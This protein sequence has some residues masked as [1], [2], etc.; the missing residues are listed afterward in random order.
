MLRLLHEQV[1][2]Y[3]KAKRNLE[4]AGHNLRAAES[5]LDCAFIRLKN[6]FIEE[7]KKEQGNVEK[8]WNKVLDRLPKQERP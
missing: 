5:A 6:H 8:E 4:L 7:S 3:A 2:E 1:Q